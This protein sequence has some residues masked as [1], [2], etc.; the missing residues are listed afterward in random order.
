MICLYGKIAKNL[1]KQA[2]RNNQFS[3]NLEYEFNRNPFFLIW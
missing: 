3:D 1:Q 2:I